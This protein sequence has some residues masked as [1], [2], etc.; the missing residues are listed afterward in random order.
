M[1]RSSSEAIIG[2]QRNHHRLIGSQALS[3]I[4]P[5]AYRKRVGK[6][7]YPWD[8]NRMFLI[9]KLQKEEMMQYFV[10][11]VSGDDDTDDVYDSWIRKLVLKLIIIEWVLNQWLQWKLQVVKQEGERKKVLKECDISCSVRN[12]ELTWNANESSQVTGSC[13]FSRG[14]KKKVLFKSRLLVLRLSGSPFCCYFILTFHSIHVWII[15]FIM[16]ES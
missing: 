15:P 16:F 1:F 3:F 13:Y 10:D 4:E 14:G 9:L 2:S 11:D 8:T 7:G 12:Q 6:K 5:V